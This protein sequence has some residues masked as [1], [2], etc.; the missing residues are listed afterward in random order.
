MPT[1]NSDKSK[2]KKNIEISDISIFNS[3]LFIYLDINDDIDTLNENEKE[4]IEKNIK[5]ADFSFDFEESNYLSNE[6]IE[7]LDSCDDNPY[8][9][10]EK[11]DINNIDNKIIIDS[12]ISLANNGYEFRPKNYKTFNS[13]HPKIYNNNPFNN[14]NDNHSNKKTNIYYFN[15]NIRDPKKDWICIFCN[16]LNYSF[17]TKCNRCKIG[18]EESGK[19]SLNNYVL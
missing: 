8:K 7:E 9:N 12:L 16:N 2:T 13:K 6:L 19:N 10:P 17:R 3:K 11:E 18:K 15:N 1:N 5:G 14:K 4:Y